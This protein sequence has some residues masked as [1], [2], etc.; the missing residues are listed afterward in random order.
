MKN[1]LFLRSKSFRLEL[2]FADP[3]NSSELNIQICEIVL[4]LKSKGLHFYIAEQITH[5][6]DRSY[7]CKDSMISSVSCG[8]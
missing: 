4:T 1:S 6:R 7:C 3:R 5:N 2:P 8:V